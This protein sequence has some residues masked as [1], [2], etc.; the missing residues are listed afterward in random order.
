MDLK[1]EVSP[2]PLFCIRD[3]TRLLLRKVS[4]LQLCTSYRWIQW[5]RRNCDEHDD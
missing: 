5:T 2:H 4:A 1:S 3:L